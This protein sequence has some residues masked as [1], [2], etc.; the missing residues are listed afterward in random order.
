[1]PTRLDTPESEAAR[2]RRKEARVWATAAA[3]AGMNVAVTL[4]PGHYVS[5]LSEAEPSIDGPCRIAMQDLNR[6]LFGF[7]RRQAARKTNLVFLG[8]YEYQDKRASLFPHAH[9]A[10]RLDS[11]QLWETELFLRERWGAKDVDTAKKREVYT[12]ALVKPIIR[13][14][15]AR[16]EFCLEQITDLGGWMNFIAKQTTRTSNLVLPRQFV[17]SRQQDTA[18]VA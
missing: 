17:K 14:P 16:P 15:H 18:Q 3:D 8:M 1:M 13:N 12:P 9:L 6:R 11:S 10:M 4:T 2:E 7:K 5:R